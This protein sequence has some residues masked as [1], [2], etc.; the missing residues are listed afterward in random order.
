MGPRKKIQGG[1][2]LGGKPRGRWG[3]A[4]QAS[5]FIQNNLPSAQTV[6]RIVKVAD[7]Y[8][9]K[10][11]SKTDS[12]VRGTFTVPGAISTSTQAI[13]V[14]A[15]QGKGRPSNIRYEHIFQ[16]VFTNEE[17][18]QFAGIMNSIMGTQYSTW[19]NEGSALRNALNGYGTNLFKLTPRYKS[20]APGTSASSG[21]TVVDN[22]PSVVNDKFW[23]NRVKSTMNITNFS[24]CCVQVT[25]YWCAPV[26]NQPNNPVDAWGDA[27]DFD[28]AAQATS[29]AAATAIATTTAT[30]GYVQD[31]GTVI[32]G[33]HPTAH[34]SFSR[35]W[36]IKKTN[37]ITIPAGDTKCLITTCKYNR[38]INYDTQTTA[39]SGY[40]S[41]QTLVPMVVL[42]TAQCLVGTAPNQEVTFAIGKIGIS[43]IQELYM[44]SIDNKRIPV[45][46]MFNGMVIRTG[47]SES[48]IDEDGDKG[49]VT[50]A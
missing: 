36:D 32:Y 10:S 16:K 17:G 38:V 21:I 46:R 18:L 4:E 15:P 19:T 33:E 34:K 41:S 45:N 1:R 39:A 28:N 8:L 43:H 44:S 24:N 9:T 6:K 27:I 29:Q 2:R 25:V 31:T 14:G 13:Q 7:R 22:D 11:K 30:A 42:R 48:F 26:K 49:T 5:N 40:I 37:K 20:I 3:W 47:L 23:L 12:G 50:T 35:F